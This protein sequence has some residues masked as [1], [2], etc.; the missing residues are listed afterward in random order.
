MRAKIN[1]IRRCTFE[2][3]MI[4]F[5]WNDRHAYRAAAPFACTRV[6]TGEHR[7]KCQDRKR[8]KVLCFF[9]LHSLRV[10]FSYFYF[11]F[12]KFSTR[13][14]FFPSF[15]PLCFFSLIFQLISIRC[16]SLIPKLDSPLKMF[17][18]ISHDEF[19]DRK[20]IFVSPWTLLPLGLYSRKIIVAT[21]SSRRFAFRETGSAKTR[22][23]SWPRV[24]YVTFTATKS[25]RDAFFFFFFAFVN[26]RSSS[27][28]PSSLRHLRPKIPNYPFLA[29]QFFAIFNAIFMGN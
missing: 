1:N 19:R 15:S 28:S 24:V 27:S 20:S 4:R 14:S 7:E 13:P 16:S 25:Q 9:E 8:Y 21:C 22:H 5:F 18:L 12:I 3:F 17:R 10:K 23:A 2:I 11:R 26:R 29:H 6:Y